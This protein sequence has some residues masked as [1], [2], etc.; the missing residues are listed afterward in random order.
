MCSNDSIF[1]DPGKKIFHTPEALL[2]WRE[3]LRKEGKNLVLTNGCFDLLH[4][5]HAEYLLGA[6]RAGEALLVLLNSDESVRSLK[7]PGRPVNT[8][9]DRAY[10]LA[11]LSFVDGV[12]IFSSSRCDKEI[13]MIEPDIYAKGADYT[14]EKLDKGELAALQSCNARIAFIPLV[15]GL[16]TTILLARGK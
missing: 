11:S 1:P 3:S 7:G 9:L 15:P 16:S 5:G 6:R 13:A 4:R 10:V 2:S 8:E 12:Y 14:V